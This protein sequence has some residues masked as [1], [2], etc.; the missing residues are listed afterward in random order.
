MQDETEPTLNELAWDLVQQA[1]FASDELRIALV[2][3]IDGATVLDFG[4]EIVGSLGAGLALAE[5]C[6]A[7]W[8]RSQCPGEIGGAAGCTCWFHRFPST[9]A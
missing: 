2:D 8:R 9:P 5:V 4:V 6:M 1:L 3:E 7:D